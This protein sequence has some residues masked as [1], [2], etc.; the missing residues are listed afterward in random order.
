MMNKMY[1][2]TRKGIFAEF[3]TIEKTATGKPLYRRADDGY[4]HDVC[5]Q[6]HQL[7]KNPTANEIAEGEKNRNIRINQKNESLWKAVC[8]NK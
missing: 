3:V 6:Q 1:F 2:R 5:F 7:I 8:A 4:M